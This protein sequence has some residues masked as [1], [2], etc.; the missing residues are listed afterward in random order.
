[1]S[2]PTRDADPTSPRYQM[3]EVWRGLVSIV[4]V[5]EH[6][7]VA[8]WSRSDEATNGWTGG[9]QRVIETVLKWNVGTPLFFVMSG[10]CIAA[11]LKASQRRGVSPL[12]FLGRRLWRIYPTY[13]AALLGL[14]VFVTVLDSTG[15]TR[16]HDNALSLK[17]ASPSTLNPAQWVGN[18]TLTEMW[19]PIVG[20]GEAAMFDR[21]A[22]SL[23]YQEQFYIVCVLAVWVAPNRFGLTLAVFTVLVVL[24][25]VAAWDA[26]MLSRI[27]GLFPIYWHEFAVG[28]AVYWRLTGTGS[29]SF[30]TRR[31]LELV[32]AGMLVVASLNHNVS[33]IAASGLGLVLIALYRWDHVTAD[34][35]W[36][37]PLRSCG[38]RSFSIYLTH[39]PVAAIG[40]QL[41][42]DLGLTGFWGRTLVMMPLVTAASIA[43][44]WAFH[45]AIERRFVP[46][47]RRSWTRSGIR[48]RPFLILPA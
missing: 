12:G 23:C 22:W 9:F 38:K 39:L 13:W 47:A 28:L 20:G 25:R 30:V 15:L 40:N 6:V 17:I 7:G 10:Y 34:L 2:E 45:Q 11:S 27:E 37:E 32:V 19:R 4:V 31:G 36:L 44:G 41:L 18:L 3:L 8:L 26:R 29:S 46:E 33:T 1:M 35:A 5:L 14:A 48:R 21:V 16:L 42:H 24:F 43:V